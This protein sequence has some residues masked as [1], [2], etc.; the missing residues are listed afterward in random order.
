MK[1]AL[2]ERNEDIALENETNSRL[3]KTST[4]T[5]TLILLK[6]G[7][8]ACY[9]DGAK[10]IKSHGCNFVAEAF[11]LRFIPMR[12]DLCH[13]DI[14][15]DPNYAPRKLIEEISVG[16]A[17]VIDAR[18]VTNTGTVGGILAL[19]LW[20]RGCAAL[21]SDG[22]M[23]DMADL[24]AG[25]LPIYCSGAAAPASL[26]SHYGSDYQNP[27]A[28]GG[29]TVVPG[30]ILVGDQ[31]GVVVVPRGMAD[32][33]GRQAYEQERLERFLQMLIEAGR[34]TLGTYPPDETTRRE[35]EKWVA[36]GE[37]CLHQRV[38]KD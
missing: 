1:S 26:T 9:I 7:I 30:D 5:A 13:P 33:V 12:E 6:L 10:P 2:V 8:R 22:A 29:V 20:E 24:I 11:T 4:A 35:Y 27:I 21:V 28:C 16:Q 34:P 18:G 14:L 19:R 37:P 17:L 15:A 3:E 31:D 23:R 38:S 32:E 36:D 25:K